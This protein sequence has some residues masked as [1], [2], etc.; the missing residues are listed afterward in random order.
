[1]KLFVFTILV[2]SIACASQEPQIV[3]Q[4][5]SKTEVKSKIYQDENGNYINEKGWEIP[6][7]KKTISTTKL[8]EIV[9]G[10][11]LNLE[12]KIYQQE[13]ESLTDEPFASTGNSNFGIIK[14]TNLSG[15]SGKNQKPFC[16]Y[17]IGHK[18]EID[19]ETGKFKAIGVGFTYKFCDRDGDG[20]YET[21][22]QK[23]F[24]IPNWV[25]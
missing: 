19:K 25:K 14:I 8:T 17:M 6:K 20:K 4:S 22:P 9:N 7:I 11:K 24:P 23:D 5:Q 13:K 1:M 10:K 12:S 3:E 15:I 2:F 18:T 21:Y 16:Y